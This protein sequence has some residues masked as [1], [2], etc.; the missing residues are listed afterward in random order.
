[1]I[2]LGSRFADY[3]LTGGFFVFTQF[4]ALWWIFPELAAARFTAVTGF[5]SARVDALPPAAHPA[6]S[7]LLV[8]LAVVSIFFVGLLLDLMGSFLVIWEAQIFKKHLDKNEEWFPQFVQENGT[9]IQSDYERIKADIIGPRESFR[10]S[11][12]FFRFWKRDAWQRAY[13][14]QRRVWRLIGALR[15]FRRLEN[16][17]IAHVLA[18]SGASNLDWLGDQLRLCRTSRAISASIVILALEVSWLTLAE[19]SAQPWVGIITQYAAMALSLFVTVRAYSRFCTTL[20][21]LTYAYTSRETHAA[22]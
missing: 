15:S 20:F 4:S 8:A 17:L 16:L 10:R 18:A 11:F 2:G 14:E 1:M 3:G 5:V 9:Y 13:G 12:A 21:S 6:F 19:T 7:S 22:A